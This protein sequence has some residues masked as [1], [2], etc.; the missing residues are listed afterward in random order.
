M[1]R[2]NAKMNTAPRFKAR[3]GY[4]MNL[5]YDTYMPKNPATVKNFGL[6]GVLPIPYMEGNLG[7]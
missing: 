6:I 4:F 7:L 1:R 3:A 5:T 2:P